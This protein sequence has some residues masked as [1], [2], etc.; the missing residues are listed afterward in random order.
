MGVYTNEKLELIQIYLK[1]LAISFKDIR[2]KIMY[3]LEPDYKGN[4]EWEPSLLEIKNLVEL[5]AVRD[6]LLDIKAGPGS[7][8]SQ[9]GQQTTKKTKAQKKQAKTTKDQNIVI[10]NLK[11]QLEAL[12]R[13]VPKLDH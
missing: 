8:V 5:R 13:V 3:D 1:G 4:I 2:A 7:Q 12:R 10:T 11:A 9:N 6:N